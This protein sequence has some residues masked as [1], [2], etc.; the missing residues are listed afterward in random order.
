MALVLLWRVVQSGR[1]IDSD[2][3]EVAYL[4]ASCIRYVKN[5]SQCQAE[6]EAGKIKMSHYQRLTPQHRSQ[7]DK[8]LDR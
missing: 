6:I 4:T 3:S 7:V 1:L 8:L 5:R 2:L